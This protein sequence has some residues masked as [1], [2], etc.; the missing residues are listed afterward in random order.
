V[1]RSRNYCCCRNATIISICIVELRLSWSTN[2]VLIG[3]QQ[4]FIFCI[5]DVNVSVTVSF[6]LHKK[7]PVFLSSFNNVCI[8]FVDFNRSLRHQI[9]RKSVRWQASR[10]VRTD[11]QLGR[12]LTRPFHHFANSPKEVIA[13]MR[14]PLATT[15]ICTHIF[16]HGTRLR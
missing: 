7:Y 3:R 4:C 9:S 15:D 8:F 11:E 14:A 6:V 16:N 10:Y 13:P 2:T 12:K 5:F 1:A